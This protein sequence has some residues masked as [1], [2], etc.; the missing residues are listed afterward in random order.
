MSETFMIVVFGL[1]ALFI[2][3]LILVFI[4]KADSSSFNSEFNSYKSEEE[5]R[6]LQQLHYY[7]QQDF[8]KNLD[9]RDDA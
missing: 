2:F 3:S 7:A 1:T 5:K 8:I 9:G 6:N 4:L